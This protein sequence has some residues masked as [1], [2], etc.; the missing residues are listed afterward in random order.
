MKISAINTIKNITFSKTVSNPVSFKQGQDIFVK[1]SPTKTFKQIIEN[2]RKFDISD[3]KSLSPSQIKEA[4]ELADEG[5]IYTAEENLYAGELVKNYLDKTYGKDKYVFACIG[6]SPSGIGRV[7]E[8]MGVE[9]KYFPA[10]NFRAYQWINDYLDENSEAENKYL[11]FINEQG[12]NEEEIN[13]KDKTILFVDYTDRGDTLERFE[14]FMKERAKID[15][16]KIKYISLND[17]LT[18][19]LPVRAFNEDYFRLSGYMTTFLTCGE[20]E[21]YAGIPHLRVQ[22]FKDIDIIFNKNTGKKPALYNLL[23]MEK[24]NEQGKLK[25]NPLNKDSL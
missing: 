10:T 15:N 9:T 6:T 13:K 14:L 8:F 18:G 1:S 5:V 7:L 19:C 3:Y 17:I 21:K 23:L 16:E 4:K 20:I 22:D 24:L 12:I 11:S 25:E 2:K